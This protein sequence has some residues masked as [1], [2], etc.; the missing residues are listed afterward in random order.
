MVNHSLDARRARKVEEAGARSSALFSGVSKAHQVLAITLAF[1]VL[2]GKRRLCQLDSL[3][4]RGLSEILLEVLDRLSAVSLG[5]VEIASTL[6]QDDCPGTVE[7]LL[8]AA[9]CLSRE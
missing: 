7:D 9:R 1:D 4:S 6:R 5:E 2:T 3:A 8:A